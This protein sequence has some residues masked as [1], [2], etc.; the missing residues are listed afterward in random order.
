MRKLIIIVSFLFIFSFGYRLWDITNHFEVWDETA[1]VRVG[2]IYLNAF[3]NRDFSMET[4][5]LNKE[6]PPF[7]KYVFGSTRVLSLR[8]PYFTEKLDQDYPIGRR[9]T[10]QRIVSTFIGSLSVLLL[11]FIIRK[12]YNDKIAILSSFSLSF[13]PYFIA[14][15]RVPTQENLVLF[16]TLL[17]TSIFFIALNSKNLYHKYFLYSGIFLGLAIATKYNA[18]FFLILFCALGLYEFHKEFIKSNILI[19]KNYIILIPAI[20]LGIFYAVWPWLWPDP[21]GRFLSSASRINDSRYLEYFFGQL[22]SPH[23]WYYFFVYIFA[24]TPPILILGVFLFLI[25]ILF[26]RNK[27]DIWFFAYF[28]TPLLAMFSPLKMDGIR[29]IFPIYPA[30][31]V[32][33]SIGF[34]WIIENSSKF[35]EASYK[36][37]TDFIIPLIVVGVLLMTNLIYHPFYWDYYNIFVGGPLG[38]YQNRLFDFGYWGEG[39]RDGMN[40]LYDSNVNHDIKKLY[41][42]VLPVHVLPPYR[43]S[44]SYT[45]IIEEADYVIIN[46]AGEWLNQTNYLDYDFP[47]H[48]DIVFEE[49]IMDAPIVQVYKRNA[50]YTGRL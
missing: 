12:F 41:I 5:K 44:I 42:K 21:I 4:W 25:K 3:K 19:F 2:E 26:N 9:Y 39:L 45:D 40:Y 17:S 11:F 16:L 43:N 8:L 30:L 36:S 7:S 35:I 32:I 49:N 15:S 50:P 48:F 28:L 6:H 20:S 14:H 18:F 37:L 34:Y 13:T 47:E 24:T 23:P 22:P 38:V 27:Y 10:F 33:S 31:A 29:Y 46:P 1:I